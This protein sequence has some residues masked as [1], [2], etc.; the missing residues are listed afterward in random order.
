VNSLG[1]ANIGGTLLLSLLAMLASG[2]SLVSAADTVETPDPASVFLIALPVVGLA[3]LLLAALPALLHR[4]YMREPP[5]VHMAKVA[6]LSSVISLLTTLVVSHAY[7]PG[8]DSTVSLSVTGVVTLLLMT[9]LYLRYLLMP[10][11]WAVLAGGAMA[12]ICVSL[13]YAVMEAPSS[14]VFNATEV[15]LYSLPLWMLVWAAL[16]AMETVR[17][18]AL[19][20]EDHR[21]PGTA[22]FVRRRQVLRLGEL[23]IINMALAAGLLLASLS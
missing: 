18:H 23:L 20:E 10:F 15:L 19:V 6:A 1:G 5:A 21:E 9:G 11:P 3:V 8:Y 17:H 14:A 16:L 4:P 12:V 13:A 7:W 22:G 2:T